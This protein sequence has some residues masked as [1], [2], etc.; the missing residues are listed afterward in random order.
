MKALVTGCAG[1]IGSNL[2]DRLLKNKWSVIGIDNLSTGQKK[3][4]KNANN[5]SLFKF[6]EKDLLNNESL[7]DIF[8]QDIDIIFHFS[9]NADVRHGIDRPTVDFEQNIVVTHNILEAMR[10]NSI[11]RIV[12]SSTGSVYGEANQIPTPEIA[13]FPV[14][15]SLYGASK[16]ACEGLIQAYSETFN[17]QSYIF[18]FVSILGNRYTHGHIYDFYKQLKE[19]PKE[20]RVLGD[21]NQ[22]KSYLHIDDCIDAILTV[23]NSTKSIKNIYNLGT[24]E[25][26][27]VKDSISWIT[28]HLKLKPKLIFTGGDKGWIG[29]NPFIYLETKNIQSLGWKPKVSIKEG[30][31]KTV[32]FISQNEW[33][34]DEGS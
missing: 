26:C 14:Q 34:L 33:V 2:V 25:Y 32:K 8:K 1:F 21:G 29:D 5:S 4:L 9:A 3:F 27:T 28:Q 7:K 20:L 22:K 24:D 23:L 31:I 17:I 6:Y 10:I 15:T 16:L 18:R 13:E 19:N 11:D 12:F 30:V